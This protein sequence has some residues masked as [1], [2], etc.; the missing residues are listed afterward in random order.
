MQR[1]VTVH[2]SS[3]R[4]R[5]K[6]AHAAFMPRCQS[7]RNGALLRSAQWIRGADLSLVVVGRSFTVANGFVPLKRE[8]D[9]KCYTTPHALSWLLLAHGEVFKHVHTIQV[10]KSTPRRSEHEG[11]WTL[12]QEAAPLDLLQPKV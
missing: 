5:F 2:Q 8:R 6:D 1:N 3:G 4:S 12:I 7:L 10:R 9:G 11:R